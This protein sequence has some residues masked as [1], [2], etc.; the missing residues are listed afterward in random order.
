MLGSLG[1]PELIFIF[2]LALLVF[3]PKKLPEIGRTLGK[4]MAE[5]R[6]ASNDFKR[7]L[8]AEMALLD[9]D[10][11]KLASIPPTFEP[12]RTPEPAPMQA[13]AQSV[14]RQPYAA[15][16]PPAEA[17]S[18]NLPE[19]SDDDGFDP[20]APAGSVSAESAEPLRPA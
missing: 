18:E 16:A 20:Y 4:G 1:L 15:A 17:A 10:D 19:P 8:N 14:A 2:V 3:G 9:E 13:P 6:K 5:F 12:V 7:T 11:K